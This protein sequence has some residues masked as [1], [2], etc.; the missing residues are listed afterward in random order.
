MDPSPH[1]FFFHIRVFVGIVTGLAVARLLTGLA[2]F[3][4]HPGRLTAYSI[5]LGWVLFLLLAVVHFWWFE[6]GLTHVEHWTF[7][8]YFFVI[9]YAALFFF[10]SAV[11]FPE[12]MEEYAGFAEYFHSRQTW[13]YGLLGALFAI[14]VIDTALKGSEHFQS[15]GPEY[16][17]R[18][19]ALFALA[20]IAMFVKDKRYHAIFVVAALIAQVLWIV[21]R[22]ELPV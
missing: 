13:F 21:R 20:V 9:C 1:D 11:L 3:V 2:R 17:I 6:F 22:F 5:H 16:P 15:L 18:Q 19:A 7:N 10:I 8:L 4:Q 12:R 14:D